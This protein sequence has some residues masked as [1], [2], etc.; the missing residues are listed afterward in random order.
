M[1]KILLLLALSLGAARAGAQ[2]AADSALLARPWAELPACDTTGRCIHK[3]YYVVADDS[4]RLRNF[5]VCFDTLRRAAMWVAYPLHPRYTEPVLRRT[6]RW[7][8]DDLP[9][10]VIRREV[11]PY[12]LKGYDTPE[13][14]RGHL[15]PSASRYL[16]RE[17]NEQTFLA[18]NLVPQSAPLNRR[19]WAD[20]EKAV[21]LMAPADTLYVVTGAHYA[22]RTHITDRAGQQVAVPTHC[23]KVL[24]TTRR[25]DTGRAVAECGADELKAVGVWMENTP[26]GNVAARERLVPVRA[27]EERTGVVFFRNLPDS[28][29]RI[30]KAQCDPS[31]WA[32]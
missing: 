20:L 27:V 9:D 2:T 15:L 11:Q 28:V 6:D 14:D 17:A 12:I 5:S 4:C 3:T 13:Y 16:T 32:L 19:H 30:V 26:A 8:Y 7:R 22:D 25:G 21:R 24:L 29:A 18:T 23:Y 10:P 1:K 31:L